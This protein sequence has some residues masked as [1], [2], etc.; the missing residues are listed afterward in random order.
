MPVAVVDCAIAGASLGELLETCR[1]TVVLE[2]VGSL[3]DQAQGHVLAF[4]EKHSRCHS[5]GAGR[6][7]RIVSTALANLYSRVKA[8]KF[9]EA[10]FYR[11]NVIHITV[12][13]TTLKTS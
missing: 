3:G 1:G 12:S 13:R 9:R 4:L 8:G 5:A 6:R 11:L 7:T 10:L 2:N